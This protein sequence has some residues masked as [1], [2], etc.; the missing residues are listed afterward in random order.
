[1]TRPSALGRIVGVYTLLLS[2]V[3]NAYQICPGTGLTRDNLEIVI[4][5]HT[6]MGTGGLVLNCPTPLTMER[7][8]I[9]Q[10]QPYKELPLNLGCGIMDTDQDDNSNLPLGDVAPWFWLHDLD[11]IPGSFVLEGAAGPLYMGGDIQEATKKL[12]Q[13]QINPK[14]HFKF[15]RK[16]VIWES[17]KLQQELEQGEW[18]A[19]AQDPVKALETVMPSIRL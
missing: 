11:D 19:M 5:E 13:E 6:E 10:F 2:S 18:K 17:G 3:S 12:E 15:F 16:Y 7:L 8:F 14:N 1:M 9:P 4:F